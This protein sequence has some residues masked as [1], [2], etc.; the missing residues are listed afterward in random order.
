MALSFLH[1]K[2][3][4]KSD[5]T[6]TS[7]IRPSDWNA[8]HTVTMATAKVLGRA[9]A[10]VGAIEEFDW[11]SF[12]RSL[13][14]LADIE[15]LRALLGGPI[16]G[17]VRAFASRNNVDPPSGWLECA[18]Q[19]LDPATYPDLYADLSTVYG[20]GGGSMFQL[21][22]LRGRVIA[23]QDD[24]GA[25][26]A[27][28]LTTLSGG[29]AGMGD[30]GGVETYSLKSGEM[31]NHNHGTGSLAL[32]TEGAHS[33]TYTRYSSKIKVDVDAPE[34]KDVWDDSQLNNT[35][36]DGAH[37][38]TISGDTGSTGSNN[39]HQ[40]LQPTITLRWIIFTGVMS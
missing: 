30:T 22:D 4:A 20:D 23:G 36:V 39:A 35:S 40:N 27:G 24:M 33:H 7:L 11:T 29:V 32:S 10:G 15:A 6:D 17:E 19:T 38:H 12:G 26:A 1:D 21:P 25:S 9:T 8:E 37:T 31:P 13:I 16:I 34:N 2:Q 14:N 18:G 3:S 5:G 28:R